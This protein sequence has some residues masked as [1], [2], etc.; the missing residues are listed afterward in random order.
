[1]RL[2]L[3]ED[4]VMIGEAASQALRD[5][6]WAV[7]WV[8]DLRAARLALQAAE[9]DAVLLDLGL[10]DGDGCELLQQLRKSGNAVPVIIVTARDNTPDRIRGLDLG[11]DD[12]VVKPFEI[13]ELMARLR[14][15]MRRKNGQALPILDNGRLSL[16]PAS[17][18]AR[19]AQGHFILSAREFALLQTLLQAPGRIFSRG[20]LESSIYGWGEEIESNMVDFLIHALRKKLGAELIRNVRGAG[21]Y[22][23]K[24]A[25][26]DIGG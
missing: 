19:S 8:R 17:H 3:I 18:E 16:D 26:G 2:L 21:W 23:E 1:M 13:D 12:Y 10:A 6:A 25:S 11:A 15:V 24:S 7:D 4:D 5:A 22:V 14:A 20:Q 9:H